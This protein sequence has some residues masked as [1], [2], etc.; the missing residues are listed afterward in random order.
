MLL[1]IGVL[2]RVQDKCPQWAANVNKNGPACIVI[3]IIIRMNGKATYGW[4]VGL[5]K[6]AAWE[7]NG[8]AY[9]L[10]SM[11]VLSNNQPEEME[12]RG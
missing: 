1:K 10:L 8:S 12:E 4:M 2:L 7:T 9:F 11:S 5:W 3:G 6:G